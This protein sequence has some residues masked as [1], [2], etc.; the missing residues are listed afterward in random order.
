MIDIQLKECCRE[1]KYIDLNMDE[2]EYY[3]KGC[4]VF[5]AITIECKHR[6]ICKAY[7]DSPKD[8]LIVKDDSNRVVIKK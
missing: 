8:S 2:S 3:G 6:P 5:K 4:A 7:I 1:C